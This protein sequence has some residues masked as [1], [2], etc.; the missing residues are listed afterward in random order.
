[1]DN[2][3]LK[4]TLVKLQDE[5]KSVQPADAPS[6]E[7]I[8]K[9]GGDIHIYLQHYDKGGPPGVHF[10]MKESLEESLEDFEATHPVIADLITRLIQALS[11]MGI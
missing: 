5:L 8:N 11:D 1:M 7:A 10:S 9:L 4:E 2:A 6:Q 3:P